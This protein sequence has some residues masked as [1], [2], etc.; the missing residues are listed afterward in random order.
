MGVR[1][2]GRVRPKLY[3]PLRVVKIYAIDSELVQNSE[4]GIKYSKCHL[5]SFT[6]LIRKLL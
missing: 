3:T 2:G 1:V 5:M 4:N 6:I